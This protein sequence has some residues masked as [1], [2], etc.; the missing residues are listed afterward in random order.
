MLKYVKRRRVD[1]EEDSENDS[2][3]PDPSTSKAEKEVTN[4]ENSPL[5]RYLLGHG[6]HMDWRRKLPASIVYCLW[7]KNIKYGCGPGK[8]R[9]TLH[10]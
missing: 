8:V 3:L 2:K 7:E 10:N 6:V 4:K 9:S 5:Q 1:R